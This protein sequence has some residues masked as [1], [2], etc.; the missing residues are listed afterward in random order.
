M[1]TVRIRGQD[2]TVVRQSIVRSL[3]TPIMWV[4]LSI[5]RAFLSQRLANLS[6]P[7]NKSTQF[8]NYLKRKLNPAH[9][10]EGRFDAG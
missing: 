9:P 10:G 5:S 7:K 4:R 2:H 8:N 6:V 3:T 1:R